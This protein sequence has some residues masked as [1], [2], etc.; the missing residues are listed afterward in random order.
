LFLDPATIERR[1]R[2]FA[3]TLGLDRGRILEWGFAQAVLSAVWDIEDHNVIG[4]EH[5]GLLLA[6]AIRPLLDVAT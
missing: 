5:P 1:A 2:R 4:A 6:Q 3:A